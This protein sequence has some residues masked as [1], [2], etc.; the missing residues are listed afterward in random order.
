MNIL[1]I[2]VKLTDNI[3]IYYSSAVKQ[4]SSFCLHNICVL[5]VCIMYM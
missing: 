1:T 4:N 2:A 5:C 3:Y